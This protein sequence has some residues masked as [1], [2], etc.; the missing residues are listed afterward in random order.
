MRKHLIFAFAATLGLVGCQAEEAATT[1]QTKK[2][3]VSASIEAVGSP[4]SLTKTDLA[5]FR[6]TGRL[7]V[8]DT[9]ETA[10]ELFRPPKNSYEFNDLPPHFQPPA[11]KAKG[12]DSRKEGFGVIL[13]E[14]RIAFAMYQI[15]KGDIDQFNELIAFHQR[16]V[17]RLVMERLDGKHVQYC[18]WAD[19]N[20]RL[21]IMGLESKG[22]MKI[23]IALGD[24]V[25]LKALGISPEDAK[26]DLKRVDDLFDQIHNP[27]AKAE[28]SAPTGKR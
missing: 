12:W 22:S 10:V 23:T 8:G 16:Q 25:V 13:H 27:P 4:K 18:F 20:Q 17:G 5:I 14:G 19:E 9:W 28:N 2:E 3:D 26:R 7:H 15:A 24:D 21:M 6:D 1:P 11:Y